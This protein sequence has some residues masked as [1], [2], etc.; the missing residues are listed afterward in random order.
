VLLS[1]LLYDR[2]AAKGG[3]SKG[4]RQRRWNFNGAVTGDGN[5]E[6]EVMGCDRFRRGRS[7]GGKVAR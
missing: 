6:G 2:W 7:G 5:E 1:R 4:G 3:W